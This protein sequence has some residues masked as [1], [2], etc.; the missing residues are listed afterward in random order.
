MAPTRTRRGRRPLAQISIPQTPRTEARLH[1]QRVGPLAR[2]IEERQSNQNLQVLNPA[3]PNSTLTREHYNMMGLIDPNTNRARE[4]DHGNPD[5]ID[6]SMSLL[7]RPPIR[8]DPID[9]GYHSS[10][11]TTTP[12]PL[13]LTSEALQQDRVEHRLQG[14]T[15]M[16]YASCQYQA[17]RPTAV[18]QRTVF[19]YTDHLQHRSNSSQRFV[20]RASDISGLNSLQSFD[21]QDRGGIAHEVW[22]ENEMTSLMVVSNNYRDRDRAKS[23]RNQFRAKQKLWKDWC[24]EKGYPDHD[25]VSPGKLAVFLEQEVFPKGNRSK[26]KRNGLALSE[27]GIEGYIKPIVDLWEVFSFPFSLHL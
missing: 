3:L 14:H 20:L 12:P 24:E 4:I 23:C 15:R 6:G 21:P 11:S 26:G 27:Q 9:F 10:M 19:P 13:A 7:P 8:P 16:E 1:Q 25:R 18:A 17:P 5:N 2:E 22:L